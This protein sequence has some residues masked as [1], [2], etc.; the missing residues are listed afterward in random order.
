MAGSL[1]TFVQDVAIPAIGRAFPCEG[2]ECTVG[3]G[4]VAAGS[5]QFPQL[6]MALALQAFGVPPLDAA[7]SVSRL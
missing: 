3:P 6:A 4:S 7:A 2:V 1:T 5:V